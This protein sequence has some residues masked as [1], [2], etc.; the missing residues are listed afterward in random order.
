MS[1]KQRLL[2]VFIVLNCTYLFAQENAFSKSSL[3]Y[4]VGVGIAQGYSISGLGTFLS[5]GY[6]YSLLDN[7]LRIQPGLTLGY[8][9]NQ[10]STDLPDENFASID[11][12]T[13]A[14]YDLLRYKAVS[15]IVGIGGFVNNTRGLLGTGGY[16]YPRPYSEFYSSWHAGGILTGGLRIN[17][18]RSRIAI[19]I[20]PFNLYGG[21]DKY[22]KFFAKVGFE[23]KL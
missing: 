23:V 19:E 12:E 1:L 10:R 14:S 4:S 21:F 18:A 5:M 7:H 16:E 20:S 11:L 15:L 22:F 17:P 13:L 6:G 8:L 2:F 9:D 3:R